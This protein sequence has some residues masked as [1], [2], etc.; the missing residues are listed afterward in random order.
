M[1]TRL[2]KAVITARYWST[3]RRG[4]PWTCC[5]TG[6]RR[7]WRLGW[8][9]RQAA[10]WPVGTGHRISPR[11]P[12]LGRPRRCRSLIAGHLRNNLGEA[13]ER[14]VADHRG[15]L[16]NRAP[17]PPGQVQEPEEPTDTPG[18]PL[19]TGHRF[20]D[21]NKSQ[22]AA[23]H[24]L[25][26]DGHSRRAIQ[27]RLGTTYRTVKLLAD[28][29]TPEDLFHGQGRAAPRSWMSSSL[30][31]TTAGTRAAPTPGRY[32]SAYSC[33]CSTEYG[34]MCTGREAVSQSR[35]PAGLAVVGR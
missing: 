3:S 17:E 34:D 8:P 27:R 35:H 5:P 23:V 15:R 4:D 14:C 1:R 28:A 33:E 20:A 9:S 6:R 30:I 29:A 16:L 21:R 12:P 31:W 19:P 10:R 24:A 22:S 26:A 25:L 11:A 13:A 18:S 7:A 32:V 2:A